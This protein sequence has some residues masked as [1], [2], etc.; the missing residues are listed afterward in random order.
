MNCCNIDA[1]IPID[2]RG[3][4]VLPKDLREK[5]NIKAGDKFAVISWQSGGKV[6]CISLVK[7]DDFADTVKGMLGPLMGEL[8][9][10]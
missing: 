4:V 10:E 7:A 8:L 3:Q 2:A 5:A 6:C 1:I 9:K